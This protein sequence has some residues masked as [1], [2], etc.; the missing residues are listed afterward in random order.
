MPP[1]D[2]ATVVADYVAAWNCADE[3]DRRALLQRSF[4]VDGRYADPGVRIEGREAL[5]GHARRFA[6]RC[7]GAVIELTSAVDA[8]GDAACFTWRVAGPDG[9]PVHEGI[10]VVVAGPDGRLQEVR[11]FFGAYRSPHAARPR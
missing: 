1:H 9:G 10:D 4:A 5:V 11:G 6:T 7:P 8:H 2:L 3:A